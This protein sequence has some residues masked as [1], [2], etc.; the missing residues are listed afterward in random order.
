MRVALRPT[1]GH[2]LESEDWR[3]DLVAVDAAL[4][5]HPVPLNRYERDEVCRVLHGLFAQYHSRDLPI[6]HVG[7]PRSPFTIV[8]NLLLEAYGPDFE[9]WYHRYRNKVSARNK[10]DERKRKGGGAP[11]VGT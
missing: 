3:V 6:Y 2:E 10:R 5:G 1:L 4:R 7:D 9:I 8:K 11:L